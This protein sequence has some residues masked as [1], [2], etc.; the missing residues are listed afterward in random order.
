MHAIHR[1]RA[2]GFTLLELLVVSILMVGLMMMTAQMWKHYTAE[3]ADLSGR[4]VAA[5]ELRLAIDGLAGDLGN[6]VWAV[7]TTDAGLLVCRA[8]PGASV[9]RSSSIPSSRAGLSGRTSRRAL[10]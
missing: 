7:P 1:Q 9:T 6:V 5:R 8:A 10:P 4:T 2:R 3:A